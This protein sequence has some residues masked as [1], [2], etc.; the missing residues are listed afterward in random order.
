MRIAGAHLQGGGA[1]APPHVQ[2]III[3]III[4]IIENWGLIFIL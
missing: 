1:H 3:I 4:I 2:N